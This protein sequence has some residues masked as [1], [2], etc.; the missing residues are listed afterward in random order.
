MMDMKKL[1]R[2]GMLMAVS[3]A[4]LGCHKTQAPVTPGALAGTYRFVSK[5]PEGR[6]TDYDLNH[7]VLKSDGTYDLVEGGTTKAVLERNGTWRIVPG[8][9]PNVILD[10]A[11][12]PIEITSNEVRLLIDLD[13]GIWW[14]KAK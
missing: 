5:D 13:V 3:C 8:S 4:L 2:M 11:G 1:F 12:Y 6:A 9:P 10:H 7:L 14:A